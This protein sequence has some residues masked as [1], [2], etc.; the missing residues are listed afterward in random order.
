M[1]TKMVKTQTPGV[2]KRGSRYVGVRRVRG[3][4][5]KS[6]HRTLAEAREAKGRHDGGHRRVDTKARFEDYANEWLDTYNGRTDRGIHERTLAAYRAALERWAFPFF[7]GY[8]LADVDPADMRRF[9]KH[10]GES[11][12]A[13]GSI[14]KTMVPSGDVRHGGRGRRVVLQP[15]AGTCG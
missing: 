10:L 3:K 1:T 2:Y 7:D 14:R 12:L 13:P 6:F 5:V 4:Q 9:V 11:G 15:R 8:R